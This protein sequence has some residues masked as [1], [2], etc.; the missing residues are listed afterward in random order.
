MQKPQPRLGFLLQLLTGRF[1][2]RRASGLE[3]LDRRGLHTLRSA[4]GGEF[5]AL[6]FLQGTETGALDLLEVREE[7]FA[8][9]FRSDESKALGLVKPLNGAGG[10]IRHIRTSFQ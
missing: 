3:R 2:A 5:H 1:R 6:A 9:A 7:V 8:A 4:L 10:D